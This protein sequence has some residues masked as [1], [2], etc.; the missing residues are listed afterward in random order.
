MTNHEF[1]FVFDSFFHLHRIFHDSIL[2]VMVYL[3]NIASLCIN[4]NLLIISNLSLKRFSGDIK[5]THDPKNNHFSNLLT[6]NLCIYIYTKVFSVSLQIFF[7]IFKKE[8]G[9][10]CFKFV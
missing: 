1:D 4:W 3:T 10:N 2:T 8:V 6:G 9:E 7:C 5:V